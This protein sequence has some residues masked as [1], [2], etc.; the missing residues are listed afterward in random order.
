MGGSEDQGG[1]YQEATSADRL[2]FLLL[3]SDPA[4]AVVRR[5]AD[6]RGSDLLP[7]R[8]VG[9]EKFLIVDDALDSRLHLY[10]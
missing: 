5:S 7:T 1:S 6:F 4:N 3:D 9:D 10:N 2:Q 8:L